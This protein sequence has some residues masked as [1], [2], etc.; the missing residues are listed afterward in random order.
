[1]TRLAIE[2]ESDSPG[3]VTGRLIDADEGIVF[4]VTIASDSTRASQKRVVACIG[5][6]LNWF[7]DLSHRGTK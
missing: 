3:F 6:H 1:V 7:I 5:D 4:A 2:L